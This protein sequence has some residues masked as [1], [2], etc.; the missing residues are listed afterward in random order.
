MDK[1]ALLKQVDEIY[2]ILSTLS[3][4]GDALDVIAAVRSKLR[5][6][7]EGLAALGNA[8][9]APSE[10]PTT[11]VAENAKEVVSDGGQDDRG[12]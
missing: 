5:K 9:K 4:S 6:L 12:A 3:A 8:A 10:I 7:R 2:A 1:K 11:A